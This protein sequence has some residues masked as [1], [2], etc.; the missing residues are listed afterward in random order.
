MKQF[1][2]LDEVFSSRALAPATSSE[3]APAPSDFQPLF[4]AAALQAAAP[5]RTPAAG[6][7]EPTIELVQADG[8]VQQIIVTCRCGERTVLDCAY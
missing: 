6:H 3:V 8:R 4:A 2:A 5:E 1:A 7:E